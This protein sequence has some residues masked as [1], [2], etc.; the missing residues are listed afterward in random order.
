MCLLS[1]PIYYKDGFILAALWFIYWNNISETSNW[2]GTV[3]LSSNFSY[4][5]HIDRLI[6][7]HVIN[8]IFYLIMRSVVPF[9]SIFLFFH[10]IFYIFCLYVYSIE[11]KQSRSFSNK[12][13]KLHMRSQYWLHNPSLHLLGLPFASILP[14]IPTTKLFSN[15]NQTPTVGT[16]SGLSVRIRSMSVVCLSSLLAW[17]WR[18]Q[19]KIYNG[20]F[21][22][23]SCI[24]IIFVQSIL[25]Y[26]I[27]SSYEF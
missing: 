16:T 2:N 1:Y 20:F 8:Y 14:T 4:I 26:L 17:L 21:I 10:N 24:R 7:Y 18:L 25:K 23:T 11:Y 27:E 12:W 9:K 6:N 15:S 13:R 22:Y 3:L 19:F 5:F